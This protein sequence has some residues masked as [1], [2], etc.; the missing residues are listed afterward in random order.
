MITLIH[1]VRSYLRNMINNRK[2]VI[3]TIKIFGHDIR[4]LRCMY[5][6]FWYIRNELF[7]N[8]GNLKGD[9]NIIVHF[10]KSETRI[11]F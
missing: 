5:S 11:T 9:E 7:W 6:V 8:T 2:K 10:L 1:I 4:K 3:R